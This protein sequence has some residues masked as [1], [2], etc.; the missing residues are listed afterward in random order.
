MKAWVE[1]DRVDVMT[2][3]GKI[4]IINDDEYLKI[5]I[6]EMCWIE[7]RDIK[8]VPMQNRMEATMHIIEDEKKHRIVIHK[9]P[10][11]QV[12]EV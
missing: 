8:Y 12:E 2:P 3:V 9:N 7:L 5:H 4:S 11:L 1:E 10:N 6:D